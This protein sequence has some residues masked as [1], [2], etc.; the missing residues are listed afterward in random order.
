[1]GCYFSSSLQQRKRNIYNAIIFFYCVQITIVFY[2]LLLSAC[3]RLKSTQYYK[4]STYFKINK[5]Y[6]PKTPFFFVFFQN[7]CH[8]S[9]WYHLFFITKIAVCSFL[10][11]LVIILK[12]TRMMYYKNCNTLQCSGFVMNVAGCFANS[13]A[14][15]VP[16]DV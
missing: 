9:R 13:Y 14:T 11:C 7:Y 10:C 8:S 12:V 16:V 6:E 15:C 5:Y 3:R 2:N 4:V 1:M